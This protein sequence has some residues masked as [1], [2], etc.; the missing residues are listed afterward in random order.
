MDDTPVDMDAPMTDEEWDIWRALWSIPEVRRHYQVYH[1]GPLT[2]NELA[3]YMGPSGKSIWEI[4]DKAYAKLCIAI[5]R[6]ILQQEINRQQH[7]SNKI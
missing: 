5:N 3:Y 7:S 1:A 4:Q 2:H 6:Y